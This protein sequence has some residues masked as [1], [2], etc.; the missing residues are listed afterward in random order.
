MRFLIAYHN[1][2]FRMEKLAGRMWEW[3]SGDR[4]TCWLDWLP[5]FCLRMRTAAQRAI[6][7][8]GF[9]VYGRKIEDNK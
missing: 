7:R 4:A 8:R 5:A 6:T 2:W 9:D 3:A 1:F